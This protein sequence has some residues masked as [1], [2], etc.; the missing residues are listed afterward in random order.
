M[1]TSTGPVKLR[2]LDVLLSDTC[3]GAGAAW[4]MAAP[5]RAPTVKV[6]GK[7]LARLHDDASNAVSPSGTMTSVKQQGTIRE[8]PISLSEISLASG[9]HEII[10]MIQQA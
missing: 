8:P 6:R 2:S 10:R 9:W 5:G 7:V 3:A 1:I 4:P